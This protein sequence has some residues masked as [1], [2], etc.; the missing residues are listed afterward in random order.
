MRHG[1]EHGHRV[2]GHADCVSAGSVHDEHAL[3]RGGVQVDV[4]NADAGAADDAQAHGF[5]EKLGRHFR[6]AAHEQSVGVANFIFDLPFRFGEIH[7]VPGRIRLQDPHDAFV[8]AIGYQYFHCGLK[9]LR[10]LAFLCV[11]CVKCFAARNS[12]ALTQRTQRKAIE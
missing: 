9:I 3:A 10:A 7:N 11:L 5:I 2:F 4:V 8:N 6:R 12:K 1:E